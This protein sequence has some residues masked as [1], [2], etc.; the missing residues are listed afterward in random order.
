MKAI[1]NT[2]VCSL[3]AAPTRASTLADEALYGMVVDILE[4]VA[5]GWY[6]VRTHYRWGGKSPLGIDGSGQIARGA[7]RAIRWKSV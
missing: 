3:L 7:W 6:R 2:S 1:V 5:P 4:E